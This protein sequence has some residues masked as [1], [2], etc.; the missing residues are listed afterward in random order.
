MN[1]NLFD[2]IDD[3]IT[4][5]SHSIYLMLIQ[6]H[7]LMQLRLIGFSKVRSCIRKVTIRTTEHIF[8]F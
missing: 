7:V 8:I 5:Q 3:D 4:Q 1:A 6:L 2:F